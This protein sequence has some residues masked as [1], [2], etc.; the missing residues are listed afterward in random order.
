MTRQQ[1]PNLDLA[2]RQLAISG[3][4]IFLQVPGKPDEILAAA[5]N[6]DA[7][8]NVDPY[9]GLLWDAAIAMSECLLSRQWPPLRTLELGCGSGLVGIAGLHAG[10]DVAF[11][12][13]V[14][15]AVQLATANAERNGFPSPVGF[16]LDW[17][18][19]L[20]QRYEL[21]IASDVLY[22]ASNHQFLLNVAERMLE[23][24]REFWI[25]DP[26]RTIAADFI[27]MATDAGWKVE[28]KDADGRETLMPA[29]LK[30]QL[31]ILRR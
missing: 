16:A 17:K 5:A 8:N 2:E 30:F 19:P 31:I 24:G 22:E 21:L 3:R 4:D 13:L 28:L 18:Q 23:D 12:D 15:D 20:D 7:S 25:G 29:R 27:K 1:F 14:P 9:W 6:D 11:T 10:L 26:G